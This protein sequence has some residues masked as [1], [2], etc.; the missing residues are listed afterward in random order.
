[1]WRRRPAKWSYSRE[2]PHLLTF[3]VIQCKIVM[4]GLRWVVMNVGVECQVGVSEP[5]GW[6]DDDVVCCRRSGRLVS[7][8]VNCFYAVVFPLS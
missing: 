2:R 7:P 6:H 1:M 5:D 3:V 8:I 4:I